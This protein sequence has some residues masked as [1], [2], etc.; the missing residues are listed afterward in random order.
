MTRIK[1]GVTSI[2][3]R[4]NVLKKTKG[5]RFGRSTKERKAKEAVLH[6]GMHAFNDRRDKKGVFR[7]L[8]QVRMNAALRP[9]GISYSA[10]MGKAKKKNMDINRKVLSELA[11][12]KP[13]AFKRVVEYTLG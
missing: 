10:F 9:L 12:K 6:A 4:R 13:D 3:R 1:R 7:G 11:L 2:K 8:W 5:Y